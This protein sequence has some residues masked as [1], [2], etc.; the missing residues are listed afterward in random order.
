MNKNYQIVTDRI[1]AE[2][3]KGNIPWRKPWSSLAIDPANF[4]SKHE[5]RGCN[6]LFLVTSGFQIPFYMTFKQG[7]EKGLFV[8]SGETGLPIFYWGKFTGEDRK[9]PGELKTCMF[10]KRSTV[11]NITQFDGWEAL[12]IPTPR[13]IEFNP[14]A[15]AEFLLEQT[16]LQLPI[17]EN[18]GRACYWPHKHSIDMPMRETFHDESSFYAVLFHEMGHATM[19]PLKREAGGKFGSA[20]YAFEELVAELTAAFVCAA[21]GI[22]N[23]Y[24]ENH[25]AYIQSWMGHLKKAP[26]LF[27]KAASKAQKA[28]DY[29]LEGVNFDQLENG[30]P[31]TTEAELIPDDEIPFNLVSESKPDAVPALESARRSA[32]VEQAQLTL[33]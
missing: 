2:L 14:I 22:D 15:R 7:K 19:K 26:E 6:W 8:R 13:K 28:A 30:Q 18:G 31:A 4:S 24:V 25:A 33:F 11:F 32:E 27:Y 16:P 9:N 21:C 5:Y 17:E 1:L 23:D 20:S 3:E 29:I 10:V 12:D